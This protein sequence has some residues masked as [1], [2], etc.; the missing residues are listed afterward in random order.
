MTTA[1][2]AKWSWNDAPFSTKLDPRRFFAGVSQE[3]SLSRMQF[4]VDNRRRVG[5]LTGTQGS[6]KSMLL[7]VAA[8]QFRQQNRLVVLSSV[9]GVDV[10]EFLWKIAAGLGANPSI[11]ASA[12]RLW[13]DIED[14]ISSNRYLR[15]STVILL[16]DVEEAETEVLAS[17]SRLLQLDASDDSQLT[18]IA[19]CEENRTHLLGQRLHDA[20]DLRIELEPWTADEVE[21]FVRA[22][23]AASACG[24]DLFTP[25]AVARLF[26][27]SEGMPRRVQQLAQLALVAAAA[28]DLAEIGEDTVD[29]VSQE[30]SVSGLS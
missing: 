10:D 28:Q 16:D 13:R 30:L 21:N 24:P 6:G 25:Q 7:E 22:S 15:I 12:R 29:A 11:T 3:E 20:C 1:T 9:V 27:L 2:N 4:L 23:L 26:E 8:Q 18:L 17:I 14:Q 5:V 19:S